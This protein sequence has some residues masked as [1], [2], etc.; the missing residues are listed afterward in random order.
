MAEEEG[1]GWRPQ[2]FSWKLMVYSIVDFMQITA[3]KLRDVS[4]GNQWFDEVQDRW[5]YQDF[6]NSPLWRENWISFDCAYYEPDQDRVYLGVTSFNA[7]IFQ[8]YDRPSGR[9]VEVGFDRVANSFDAKFHRSLV[10]GPDGCLYAAVALLHDVDQF[11]EAP[12]SPIIRFDP[13]SGAICRFPA[14]FPHVYIQALE[15][16]AERNRLYCLCFAPEKLTYVDLATNEPRDLGLIGSGYG[17]MTQGENLALDDDGC[18]WCNWSLTRAWQDAPGPNAV[19]LCKFDPRADRIIFY[20]K[21]L[22]WPDGRLGTVRPEAFFNLH[23]GFVYASG[24][25]GSLYRIDPENGAAQFLFT[26][27]PDRPSRL[28]SL[29][30]CGD[31]L[32]YGVTGRAGACELMLVHYRAG[33][34]E[35]L[36]PIRDE[37]GCAMWQCHHLVAAAEDTLY[38]CENDNPYRSSYLW[39]VRL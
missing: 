22:P 25:A 15:M 33:M 31:G 21:G 2:K 18:V 14:P 17:G 7:E 12:G 19:R 37:T 32:A 30:R 3:L 13:R 29:V 39:E 5:L 4:F 23:D 28:T 16:D 34:F 38:L 26:P 24:A 9:F 11:Q 8:A 27:T 36:G 20:Q 6:K 1:F 10:K 35:K